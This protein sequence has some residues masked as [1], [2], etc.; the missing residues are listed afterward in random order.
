[1]TDDG[2]DRPER[3]IDGLIFDWGGVFS[4]APIAGMQGLER[5]LGWSEGSLLQLFA[6]AVAAAGED[7][8]PSPWHR[9]ET[10]EIT[11]EQFL[12][13]VTAHA[14]VVFGEEPVDMVA[15]ATAF[16]T[17]EWLIAAGTHWE[18]VHRIRELRAD[19][20]RTGLLTN[21]VAE[22]SD[23]WRSTIPVD[24][25]FD[26]VVDSSD[27]GLRKPD[28]AIYLLA[29]ERLGVAPERT[30]FLDDAE[31]NVEAAK[32]LGMRGIVVGPD[33]RDALHALN[34]LLTEESTAGP[35]KP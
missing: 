33:P 27:V 13:R 8:E 15:F 29:C 6:A 16:A 25:L 9:L 11:I 31:R 18:V 19:G 14:P 22:W 5:R 28:P 35:A 32:E 10:G 34:H 2:V 3:G 17:L 26:D 21:N 24:E 12:E 30:V 7:D 1:M 20:Y 23:A 4:I